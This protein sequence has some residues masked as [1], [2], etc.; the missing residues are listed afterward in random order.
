MKRRRHY[1]L[2]F[3]V[4]EDGVS[5][6]VQIQYYDRAVFQRERHWGI[7]LGLFW[8]PIVLLSGGEENV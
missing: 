5:L 2:V 8:P 3:T 4:M 6:S 7:A 1:N